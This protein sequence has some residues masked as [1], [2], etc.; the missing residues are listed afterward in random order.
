MLEIRPYRESDEPAVV[1]LWR[2]VLADPAP[3]NDPA[4]DL[5]RKL[6]VRRDW[7][8]VATWDAA[9]V[10]TAMAGYD[11]HRGWVYRVAVAPGHRRRGVGTALLRRVEAAL[12]AAGCPKVNLQV[13]AANPEAIAFYESL[14]FRIED[15]I[16]LGKPL[17]PGGEVDV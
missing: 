17:P 8:F 6:T 7:L 2:E 4:A 11:G 14:G 16:S 15:R 13:R 5:R 9:V 1:A 10:G 12:V 3:W